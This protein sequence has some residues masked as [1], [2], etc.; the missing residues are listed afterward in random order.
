MLLVALSSA[1]K[2]VTVQTNKQTHKQTVN[3][4]STPCLLACVDNN[5]FSVAVSSKA[6]RRRLRVYTATTDKNTCRFDRLF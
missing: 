2:S 3:D 6:I 1:E 4:I 5:T